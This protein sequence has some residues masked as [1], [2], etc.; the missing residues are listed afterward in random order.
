MTAWWVSIAGM[1]PAMNPQW[2]CQTSWRPPVGADWP[3]VV[4]VVDVAEG[5]EDF[6]AG[7]SPHGQH[8]TEVFVDDEV[9]ALEV[10]KGPGKCA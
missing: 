7:V 5:L 9:A 3:V 2:P 10:R 8:G 1:Q 4:A 6:G